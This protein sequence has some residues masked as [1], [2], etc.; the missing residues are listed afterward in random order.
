VPIGNGVEVVGGTGNAI[1]GNAIFSNM[2][3]G[4]DLN[5]QGFTAGDG[6]TP[7]TPGG[8]HTGPNDLQNYPV[9]TSAV[10]SDAS[11][12]TGTLN[13]TPNST[14]RLEFFANAAGDPSSHGEGETYTLRGQEWHIVK[15]LKLMS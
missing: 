12:I 7:N 14:F 10:T 15:G 13:S 9:L 8:P 6:V 11:T 2:L 1:L 3:L 5:G 4:I